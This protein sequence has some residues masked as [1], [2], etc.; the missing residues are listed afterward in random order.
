MRLCGGL[1]KIS[2]KR[3]QIGSRGIGVAA[4]DDEA[5]DQRQ[6]YTF[7][8]EPNERHNETES[9]QFADHDDNPAW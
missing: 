7:R 9:R 2:D 6:V 8:N 3:G 1:H 4:Q 5:I